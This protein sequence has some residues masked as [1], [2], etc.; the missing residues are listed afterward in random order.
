MLRNITGSIIQGN[1]Q[2]F[3]KTLES[4]ELTREPKDS[5]QNT[6]ENPPTEINTSSQA[7]RVTRP[8]TN[9]QRIS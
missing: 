2:T 4:T 8:L 1:C 3:E 7:T 5:I 9:F 6:G